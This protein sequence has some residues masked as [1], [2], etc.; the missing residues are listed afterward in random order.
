M[1]Y[2]GPV[3]AA[4]AA[5]KSFACA[6]PVLFNVGTEACNAQLGVC[7]RELALCHLV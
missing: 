5:N 4:Q 2:N 7:A 6:S 3:C 1:C